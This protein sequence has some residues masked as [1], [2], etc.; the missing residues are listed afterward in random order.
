MKEILFDSLKKLLTEI[1]REEPIDINRC[2]NDCWEELSL[3]EKDASIS[4]KVISSNREILEELML[5]LHEHKERPISEEN[6]HYIKSKIFGKQTKQEDGAAGYSH[7]SVD[8]SD[9]SSLLKEIELEMKEEDSPQE[10]RLKRSGSR[11]S[12]KP[13]RWFP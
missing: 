11:K 6:L 5:I 4:Q 12:E 7:L 8:I 13:F 3:R 9:M 2:L 1:E 10:E